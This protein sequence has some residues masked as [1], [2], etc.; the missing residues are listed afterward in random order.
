M[1]LLIDKFRKLYPDF[2]EY[3][4]IEDNVVKFDINLLVD[5]L[6]NILIESSKEYIIFMLYNFDNIFYSNDRKFRLFYRGKLK[7]FR[8]IK[9]KSILT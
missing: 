3:V 4:S 8:K 5:N 1:V 6:N 2:V 7:E 9:M